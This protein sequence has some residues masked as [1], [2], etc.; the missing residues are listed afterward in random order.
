MELITASKVQKLFQLGTVTSEYNEGHSS[1][2]TMQIN[3]VRCFSKKR[4]HILKGW[5]SVNW[6]QTASYTI[7]SRLP[8]FS[9]GF[10]ADIGSWEVEVAEAFKYQ[11]HFAETGN[12]TELN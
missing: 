11:Q 3:F 5:G 9:I 8:V 2:H 7:L 4:K 6:D 12:W 1:F 10:E